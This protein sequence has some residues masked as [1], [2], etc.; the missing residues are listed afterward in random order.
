MHVKL[1]ECWDAHEICTMDIKYVICFVLQAFEV[2]AIITL[3][4]TAAI[5]L[6]V[7]IEFPFGN[8]EKMLVPSPDKKTK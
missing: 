6:A 5:L 1:L 4:Y 3:A 8:L 2:A 7:S